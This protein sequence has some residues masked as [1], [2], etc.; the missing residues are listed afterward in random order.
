MP[1]AG[2]GEIDSAAWEAVRADAFRRLTE[3]L[4]PDE[5]GEPCGTVA[6]ATQD[7]SHYR[8]VWTRDNVAPMLYFL[9]DESHIVRSFLEALMRRQSRS[10][11][12]LGLVPIGF[13]PQFDLID[14]GG[15][16]AIGA[17]YSIDSTLWFLILVGLYVET[18]GD[19]DWLASNRWHFEAALGLMLAPRFDPLPLFAA[20]ESVTEIDRPADLH[21]YPLQLQVLASLAL[22]W[23]K[24]MLERLGEAD[25]ARECEAEAQALVSWINRWYWLDRELIEER[26]GLPTEIHGLGNPNP[27]NLDY[28]QI[29]RHVEWLGTGGFLAGTVRS[30]HLSTRLWS[31]PNC[32]AAISGIVSEKR[33]WALAQLYHGRAAELLGEMP[34]AVC[35]P[36]LRGSQYQIVMDSDP[37]GRPGLF[38]N[39]SYW[40]NL[41]WAFVPLCLQAGARDLAA[42]ALAKA[43]RHLPASWGEYYDRHGRLGK[44]ARSHQTWSIAGFLLAERE[45]HAPPGG[46]CW[47]LRLMPPGGW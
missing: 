30:R 45:F 19:L 18:T 15:E 17:V 7:E 10:P 32:L 16:G 37:R 33:A 12:T 36:D 34:L 29:R 38:H 28:R 9:H 22:R 21:G 43:A 27:F 14:Y 5:C 2:T 41:L 31:F 25:R 3:A 24:R 46:A 6:S 44:G 47:Q 8:N 42:H 23:S 20:P 39:G 1:R 26:L 13:S 40:P 11:R 4:V 35:W